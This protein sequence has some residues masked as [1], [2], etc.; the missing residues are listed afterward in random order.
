LQVLATFLKTLAIEPY[1]F[2]LSNWRCGENTSDSYLLD[3]NCGT[4]ACAVGWA[5]SM[6]ELKAE[7]LGFLSCP[8]FEDERS[9]EAV[10]KFFC[11]TS[12]QAH[13]FFSEQGYGDGRRT[14]AKQVA[15]RIEDYLSGATEMWTLANQQAAQRE[16]WDLFDI[17]GSKC[18]IQHLDFAEDWKLADGSYATQLASDEAAWKIVREGKEPHHI[19]ALQFIKANNPTEYEI[20]MK[21]EK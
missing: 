11:L 4:T 12:S 8:E 5:C 15:E 2:N 20:I 1:K 21:E 7:G 10:E 18:Q 3:N 6:P 13:N 19:N 14:S 16:G 9:W 17:D